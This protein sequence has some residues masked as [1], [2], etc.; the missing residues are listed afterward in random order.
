[1]GAVAMRKALVPKVLAVLGVQTLVGCTLPY[2]QLSLPTTV[3]APG[4]I[5]TAHGGANRGEPWA[6][7]IEG[8]SERGVPLSERGPS[9]T[10]E[11]RIYPGSGDFAAA[12]MGKPATSSQ[13]TKDG[14]TLNL[15]GASISEVAKTVLGDVLGVN[16]IVSDRVKSTITLRTARPVDKAGLL[17]IFD[18]VLR[19][20]GIALVVDGELYKIVPSNEAAAGGAPLRQRKAVGRFSAG[21]VTEIVPLRYVSASEMERILKSAAPQAGI[22]RVDSARNLLVVSGTSAEISALVELVSTFDV[23]WMRGMSFG[24]FPV[25]TSDPEAIASATRRTVRPKVS[26]ASCQT[27]A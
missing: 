12:S 3:S 24:I 18:A 27:G 13:V 7:R 25:E 15:V 9:D 22:L 10:K 21:V 16:Y 1:M 11:P 2:E 19:A 20:E 4:A 14:I 17:E 6:A 26:C 23:D 8:V 5:A